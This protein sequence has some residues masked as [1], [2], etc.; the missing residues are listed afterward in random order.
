MSQN[1][2]A[3]EKL[4]KTIKTS[5]I[6]IILKTINYLDRNKYNYD[7]LEV[8]YKVSQT[9]CSFCC[10][11]GWTDTLHTNEVELFRYLAL[12]S[13]KDVKEIIQEEINENSDCT[14]SWIEQKDIEL[15]SVDFI[16]YE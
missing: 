11:A 15:V 5:K 6:A 16:V 13:T 12:Y 9:K 8:S 7:S 10:V 14:K 3:Q 4:I 2:F 1:K